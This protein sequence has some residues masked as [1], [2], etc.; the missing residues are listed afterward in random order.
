MASRKQ[1][2]DVKAMLTKTSD[3]GRPAYARSVVDRKRRNI[4]IGSTNE[5]TPLQDST[6]NRRFLPVWLRHHINIEWVTANIRQ[7]IGEAAQLESAGQT[8]AVPKE[9][10]EVA[11]EHQ[12][13]ARSKESEEVMFADWFAQPSGFDASFVMCSDLEKLAIV[14]GFKSNKSRGQ[15]MRQ[16]GFRIEPARMFGKVQK[17]WIRGELT[18]RQLEASAVQ[19]VVDVDAGRF[20]RVVVRLPG[21]ELSAGQSGPPMPPVVPPLPMVPR[22]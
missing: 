14:A 7:L 2:E 9:L 16:L 12:E 11:A 18:G 15:V 21:P 20:P 22:P 13:A 19:F 4:F 8:F 6:G 5:T 3:L 17:I 10:W 1:I